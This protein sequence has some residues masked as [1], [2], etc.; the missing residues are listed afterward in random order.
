MMVV[1]LFM[2]VVG[3]LLGVSRWS[4]SLSNKVAKGTVEYVGLDSIA[5]ADLRASG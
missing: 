5:N 2:M 4:L 3:L 1:V